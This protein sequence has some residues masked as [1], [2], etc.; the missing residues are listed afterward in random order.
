MREY[1][2]IDKAITNVVKKV[3]AIDVLINNAGLALGAPSQFPNLEMKDI[4]TM[5]R[6]N[7]EGWWGSYPFPGL[8]C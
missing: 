8:P 2:Q 3:G 4:I 1:D 5:S 7:I 6:T